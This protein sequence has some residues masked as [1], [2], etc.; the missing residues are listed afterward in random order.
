MGAGAFW[1]LSLNPF[2]ARR[3]YGA[4][5]ASP[6]G[7]ISPKLDETTG[8][9]LL[10][11]PDGFR[12]QSFSWTGDMM[13]D[14]VRC[15][16][17]HDGMAVV[18]AQGNSGHLILV[19]NHEGGSGG[20]YV[21]KPSITYA[22]DGDGGTTNLIFDARQG[23]WMKDWSSL[24]GTIR[25]CAG[26]V[27]PWGTWISGEETF[28]PEPRLELRSRA[29]ERRSQADRRYG[30][31]LARSDDGGS[32]NRVCLRDRGR[33]TFG[34]LQVRAE[35]SWPRP[36]GRRALHAQSE[37]SAELQLRARL[38]GRPDLGC[39][40]GANRRPGR[41]RS[42]DVSSGSRWPRI[43]ARS[44]AGSR[45]AGGATKPDISSPPTAGLLARGRCSSTTPAPKR[46]S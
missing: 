32:R 40:V 26:G 3:A 45:V 19:R 28:G 22:D 46:S 9:P 24:A 18:G 13:A 41:N 33:D 35:R 20:P 1:A 38:H 17:L 6:Y 36:R 2:M 44:S 14:D 11:L 43:S 21:E 12:Y 39:G 10:R 34:L 8:L 15:P 30:T 27:T 42:D 37:E 4:A 7:A 23:R 31:V 29:A 25:N 5:I 16:N